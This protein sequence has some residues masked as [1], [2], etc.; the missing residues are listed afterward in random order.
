MDIT[1]EIS[2]YPLHEQY[3][4]LVSEFIQQLSNYHKIQITAGV[5]SSLVFGEYCDIMDTLK[6]T[7]HP[8]LEKYPSVFKLSLASACKKCENTT[9]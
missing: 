5:M 9:S 6:E 7:M 1:L 8:F 2:Y 4:K 3:D